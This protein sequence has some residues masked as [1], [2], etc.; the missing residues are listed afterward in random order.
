MHC[1]KMFA[2]VGLVATLHRIVVERTAKFPWN[3]N[4]V[5]FCVV[6]L[7]CVRCKRSSNFGGSSVRRA[8]GRRGGGQWVKL[9]DV[10]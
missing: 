6:M 7:L 8:I 10:V 4:S 3:G 1:S 9:P 2:L 5:F